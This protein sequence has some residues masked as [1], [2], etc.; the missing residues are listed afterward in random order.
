M[1]FCHDT[2]HNLLIMV[3]L[4]STSSLGHV[5]NNLTVQD[6]FM[7]INFLLIQYV[8][9]FTASLKSVIKS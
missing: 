2:I 4:Q 9:D 3:L 6:G 5:F 1:P 8:K 7:D